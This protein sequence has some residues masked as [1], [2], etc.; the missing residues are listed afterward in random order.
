LQRSDDSRSTETVSLEPQRHRA[1][2][3]SQRRKGATDERR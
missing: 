2:E 3:D 1:T